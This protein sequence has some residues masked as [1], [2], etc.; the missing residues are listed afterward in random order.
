MKLYF[1]FYVLNNKKTWIHI[2]I[3][4]GFSNMLNPFETNVNQ[5]IKIDSKLRR[6][7]FSD[8]YV[9]YTYTL[10][11]SQEHSYLLKTTFQ[12]MPSFPVTFSVACSRQRFVSMACS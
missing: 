12:R 7:R 9:A 5:D 4:M 6:T 1:V 8:I 10:S 2:F 3:A 11:N